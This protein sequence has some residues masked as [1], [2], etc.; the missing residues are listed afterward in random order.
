MSKRRIQLTFDT[1]NPAELAA[2][3]AITQS[4]A[5]YRAKFVADCIV[6]CTDGKSQEQEI[7]ERVVALL[8]AKN[9][10]V[11]PRASPAKKRGRPRKVVTDSAMAA[12]E[13]NAPDLSADRPDAAKPIPPKNVPL[14]SHDRIGLD[15]AEKQDG[16]QYKQ[17]S[18]PEMLHQMASNSLK[19]SPEEQ[20]LDDA[21]LQSMSAFLAD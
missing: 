6:R 13:M 12:V 16:E 2:Y 19:A 8:C 1:E 9:I 17:R 15:L 18:G 3:Q 21:I 7:A 10:A 20:V 14:R 11:Q 5:R 4:G